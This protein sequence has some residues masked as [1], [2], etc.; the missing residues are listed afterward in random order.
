[1]KRMILLFACVLM[2][3]SVSSCQKTDSTAIGLLETIAND[4]IYIEYNK[5]MYERMALIAQKAWDMDGVED[6]YLKLEAKY[7]VDADI[8]D[9][10]P[11]EFDALRGGRIK[12]ESDCKLDK[13]MDKLSEKYSFFKMSD[14]DRKEIREIFLANGGQ[15]YREEARRK[16]FESL[17]HS[18][19]PKN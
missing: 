12:Q 16:V 13:V 15:Q 2:G 14:E 9:I 19:T 3:M 1:M 7:G 5:I 6:L 4:P 11:H 10:P 8:C 17:N 18:R